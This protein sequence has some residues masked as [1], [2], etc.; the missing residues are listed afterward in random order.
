MCSQSDSGL[1]LVIG[2]TV[3][4]AQLAS[5]VGASWWVWCL[6]VCRTVEGTQGIA[7]LSRHRQVAEVHGGVARIFDRSRPVRPCSFAVIVGAMPARHREQ[8]CLWCDTRVF[9]LGPL[10]QVQCAACWSACSSSCVP[11]DPF[12]VCTYDFCAL[13]LN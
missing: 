6:R 5:A 11:A 9:A 12:Q 13:K 2:V 7:D 3:T 1:D 4:I 10:R 8:V